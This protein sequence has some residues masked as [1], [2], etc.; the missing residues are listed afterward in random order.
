MPIVITNTAKLVINGLFSGKGQTIRKRFQ[1]SLEMVC[2]RV[3]DGDGER[4]LFWLLS[5]LIDHS[6]VW[7]GNND[8]KS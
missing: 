8:T 5:I 7:D 3:R 2:E 4:P 1:E 6:P